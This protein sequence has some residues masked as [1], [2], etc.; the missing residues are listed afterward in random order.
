MKTLSL[1]GLF[2]L[3][4]SC[5]TSSLEIE[6]IT[7][8]KKAE[9]SRLSDASFI[10]DV[11]SIDFRSHH[12]FLTDY[13]RN[14]IIVLNEKLE[15]Q[16]L[17]GSGGEGPGEFQ[18]VSSITVSDDIIYVINDGKQTIEV[19]KDMKHQ[20]TINP[21]MILSL[22]TPL[23]FGVSNGNFYISNP[24]ST[25]SIS[26]I[27]PSS[28]IISFGEIHEF[29]SL[30]ETLI[31][32]YEHVL[33]HPKGVITVSDNLPFVKFYNSNRELVSMLDYS[34]IPIVR[35]HM[36]TLKLNPSNDNSYYI[37]AS[38]AYLS[39]NKLYVMLTLQRDNGPE[40]NKV[41]EIGV[42]NNRDLDILRVLDLGD[43]WYT[44]ICVN[45]NSLLS[46]DRTRGNIVKFLL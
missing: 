21:Q 13:Y 34:T 25:K 11:R 15:L 8:I 6:N 45:D 2:L 4:A 14:E 1:L 5:T 7:L 17:L 33:L 31:K 22:G 30:K 10:S 38:D 26:Q 40:S 43:G 32:N 3:L 18:G 19:F 35:E 46:F 41:L 44:T 16:N 9:L 36:N 37:L 39:N 28:E 24:E 23:R 29:P 42:N 12:Y 27:S 20:E